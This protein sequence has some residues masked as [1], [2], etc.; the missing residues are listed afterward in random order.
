[1]DE[2][3]DITV[4]RVGLRPSR[5][6]SRCTSWM[7]FGMTLLPSSFDEC[8]NNLE[9]LAQFATVIITIAISPVEIKPNNNN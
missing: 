3:N 1:M 6:Y 8:I 7:P 9:F 2:M 5:A 4:S